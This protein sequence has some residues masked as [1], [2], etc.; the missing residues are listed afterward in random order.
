[1]NGGHCSGIVE[2]NLHGQ[3]GTVC[4]HGWDM[5]AANVVC[6]ELG[7]GFAEFSHGA[8]FG[9]GSG[10]IALNSVQCTGHESSLIHCNFFLNENSCTHENDAGVKCTGGTTLLSQCKVDVGIVEAKS[11]L[12]LIHTFSCYENA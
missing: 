7:C 10:P 5:R 12:F 3:W 9:P 11:N 8:E 2:V 6:L 1:M 4:D